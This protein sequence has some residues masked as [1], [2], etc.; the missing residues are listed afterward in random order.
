MIQ[1]RIVPLHDT[2][3]LA[4]WHDQIRLMAASLVESAVTAGG[5]A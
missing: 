2:L 3:P 5:Q 4:E 1:S